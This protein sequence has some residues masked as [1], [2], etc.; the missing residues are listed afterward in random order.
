[1]SA[2]DAAIWDTTVKE[3]G[4]TAWYIWSLEHDAWWR[5]DSNG[6]TEKLEEA[7]IYETKEATRIVHD[8]N[9]FGVICEVTIPAY[10]I[11][12][13]RGGQRTEKMPDEGGEE[14]GTKGVD[15]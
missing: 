15:G 8:A 6:Y 10:A 3:A 7:G 9:R 11:F 2:V 5:A 12:T 1:M 4:Y 13:R 14:D